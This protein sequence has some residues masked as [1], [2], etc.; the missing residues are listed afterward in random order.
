MVK[1]TVLAENSVGVS[2][3]QVAE[4][5]WSVL[6]EDGERRVLFDTGQGACL[7]TNPGL[8]GKDLSRLDAIVLSHGHYDHTKG[9]LQVLEGCGGTE[10][11]CHPR[12]LETKKVRRSLA[13][14]E[15]NLSIGLPFTKAQLEAQGARFRLLTEPTAVTPQITASGEIPLVT[16]FETIE[17]GFLVENDQGESP[18]P[19]ADDL[20]LFVRTEKGLSVILGCAHRGV[21]NTLRA[22]AAWA[23]TDRFFALIGGN[24]LHSRSAE[25]VDKTLAALES[26]SFQ[27]IAPAHCTGQKVA[28]KIF[29]RFG[30]RA[31][32][33]SVGTQMEL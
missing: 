27:I 16:E 24:H 12:A 29:E 28:A 14:R 30:E 13:G 2:F 32:P 7:K 21:I 26:L 15:I 11:Y 3:G 18:D 4:H 10:V 22:A 5:G 8:L 17:P 25:Q 31:V 9:L 1:L 19:F 33:C 6:L 20:A 23:G